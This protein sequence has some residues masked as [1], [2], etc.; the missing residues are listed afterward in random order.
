MRI[1][2]LIVTVT[3]VGCAFEPPSL[4]GLPGDGQDGG[5]QP[6]EDS[7]PSGPTIALTGLVQDLDADRGVTAS[8]MEVSDW[9]NQA[10]TGGDD[11]STNRGTVLVVA[12]AANGHDALGFSDS[13]M[14]SDDQSAF[15]AIMQGNGY[16][17]FVVVRPAMQDQ[18][19]KNVIFGTLLDTAPFNGVTLG[20]ADAGANPY[21]MPRPSD[22]DIFVQS[23]QMR[24][25]QWTILAARLSAGRNLQTAELFIDSTTAI[26][27]GTVNIPG[28][29]DSGPLSVGSERIGGTE[30]FDGDL[31]RILIYS[32]PLTDAE[33]RE[34]GQALSALYGITT[35]F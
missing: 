35:Q 16:T 1:I 19:I 18:T 26:E 11:V 22:V 14:A 31:A 3:V 13:R 2:W 21:V 15:D 23:S 33:F 12:N 34:T 6:G 30:H 17:V 27:S 32:R 4:V 28:D 10:A 9:V 5:M 7:G 24:A 25:N 20:A 29:T 8:N